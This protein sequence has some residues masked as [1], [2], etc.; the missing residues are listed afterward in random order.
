MRSTTTIWLAPANP[1]IDK[2]IKPDYPEA[3]FQAKVGAARAEYELRALAYPSAD[4]FEP[5]GDPASDIG[6]LNR[7][8][9]IAVRYER[10]DLVEVLDELLNLTFVD[11]CEAGSERVIGDNADY[12]GHA[13][14][15]PPRMVD[16]GGPTKELV[17]DELGP[18]KKIGKVRKMRIERR[19]LGT[20][21]IGEHNGMWLTRWEGWVD[22]RRRG[23]FRNDAVELEFPL[24][25]LASQELPVQGVF[26]VLC[27]GGKK[28]L[29]HVLC[30]DAAKDLRTAILAKLYEIGVPQ[31]SSRITIAVR[32]M[33][34][35]PSA[36]VYAADLRGLYA[37]PLGSQDATRYPDPP[38]ELHH[39]TK[40]ARSRAATA[41]KAKLPSTRATPSPL[42]APASADKSRVRPRVPLRRRA[43]SD[44]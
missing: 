10:D 44:D 27:N 32:G 22:L 23:T 40:R 15:P 38:G 11:G 42:V 24:K 1:Y 17:Q 35:F 13:E 3:A 16:L 34:R 18:P 9:Q 21:R 39:Q 12:W 31:R 26:A 5:T 28:N 8:R 2:I 4:L 33:K 29:K 30:V 43:K 20:V 7:L 19:Y 14:S 41:A 36:R 6:E 25:A 37:P